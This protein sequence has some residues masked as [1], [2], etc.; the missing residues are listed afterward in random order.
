[1]V[2][3]TAIAYGTGKSNAP[4]KPLIPYFEDTDYITQ[5]RRMQNLGFRQAQKG[6]ENIDTLNDDTRNS[7]QNVANQY[8][9]KQWTDLNRNYKKTMNQMN[10]SNYQRFGSTGSTPALYNT[11]TAQKGYNDLA[12]NIAQQTADAYNDL[13]NK[14]YE[15]R[16]K[17]YQAAYNTFNTSGSVAYTHDKNNYLT[18]LKNIGIQYEQ[19]VA[20]YNKDI[21]WMRALNKMENV[22][23]GAAASAWIGPA[24]GAFGTGIE[25]IDEALLPVAYADTSVYGYY[26]SPMYDFGI[27]D[28]P[29]EYSNLM[30]TMNQLGAS[31]P[32]PTG[33]GS[34]MM[35]GKQNK[36]S[37]NT[38]TSPLSTLN[39]NYSNSSPITSAI[40]SYIGH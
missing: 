9:Q 8:T 34:N 19:D 14:E 6:L 40:R 2:L 31:Y 3:G 28:N 21:A 37:S 33:W 16:L 36:G 10:Q 23:G 11:E 15:R 20:D 38:A 18:K 39:Q 25:S 32:T 22:L 26:N 35:Y 13:V 12:A 27:I 4:D 17:N 7:L 30:Q 1:M 29:T 24:G 5:S